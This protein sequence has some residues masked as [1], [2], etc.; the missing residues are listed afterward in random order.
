M[1][2]NCRRFAFVAACLALAAAAGAAAR[3]ADAPAKTPAERE[4]AALDTLRTDTSWAARDKACRE[5]QVVGTR[6]CIPALAALLADE[7]LSHIARVALEPMP[8]DE[9]GQALRDALGKTKGLVKVGII[10]SLGFR[11]DAKAVGALA[12][13]VKDA[14][15]A[16]AEAAAA[17]LGRT[18]TPEAVAALGALR[19]SAP[20]GLQAVAAEASLTAADRLAEQ[21]KG[22]QAAAICQDLSAEKWPQAVRTA[23]FAGLLRAQPAEGVARVVKA[24]AGDDPMMRAV[25]IASVA[26]LKGA[27]VSER[28]ARELPNL[29]PDVQVLLI[30]SLAQRGDTAVGPAVVKAVSSP[31]PEVRTAAAKALGAVGDAACV[32]VL[33]KVVAEAKDPAEKQVAGAS[34]R[35]LRAD[36][37][38]AALLGCLKAAPPAARPELINVLTDRKVAGAVPDLLREAKGADEAARAAALKGLGRLAEPKDLPALLDVLAGLEGDA[39][40]GDAERAAVQVSRKVAPEAA[41]ADAVLGALAKASAVPARS[42]L[43]RVLGGIAN[44]K[45]LAAVGAALED[46]DAA[47][48]DAAVRVLADWPDARATEA[49]LGV[50]RTTASDTHRVVALRGCVRMLGLGGA[51]AKATVRSYGE[52]LKAARRPEEKK[53]VLAGLAKVADPAA[54]AAVEPLLA[55]ADVAAE[56]ELALV[57]IARGIMGSARDE[58]RATAQRLQAESK[59]PA[60]RDQAADVLRQLDKFEDYVTAWQVSG[61]YTEDGKGA[62]ALFDVAFPPEKPDAKDVAWR[63][64]EPSA[65]EQ[66]WMFDLLAA[67][68][69]EQRVGYV[70]TWI[71]S[72]AEQ[73]ARLE[74]GTD[75]GNKVWL[76][77]KVVHAANRGGA[78]VPGDFKV[79]VTLRQGWNTL[80]VKITQDTGPWQFCLRIRKADGGKLEGV[81]AQATPPGD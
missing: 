73:P 78:A 65:G 13:L 52:L 2:S 19:G 17:A 47:V 50:F 45:S 38:D 41:Q 3:A 27:G 20:E 39:G 24:L 14:D 60:V 25:A 10:D 46:K 33:C 66:P 43:L 79:P 1:R 9:A 21:G 36:G 68:G 57:A 56:A 31:R 23:A 12:A 8:Y 53:L 15:A 44:A 26:D 49:V 51:P 18:A 22:D 71:R 76:N 32:E 64:L 37:V 69:G 29:A 59:T 42:S 62:G 16:I 72:Q 74:F 5:L 75:D 61:P 35:A 6:K 67:L 28:F 63:V 80:L 70:R 7:Q 40:R 4:Q 81:R 48:Q 77:G 58:A 54:L 55:D 30:E 11:R 34:L